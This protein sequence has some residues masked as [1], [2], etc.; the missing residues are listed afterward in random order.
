[1]SEA[2]LVAIASSN[3]DELRILGGL[4]SVPPARRYSSYEAL[5]TDD[6]VD[7]I[8]VA[9]PASHHFEHT[10]LFLTA[11]RGVVCETPFGLN[12]AQAAAMVATAQA[13]GRFLMETSTRNLPVYVRLRELMASGAIGTVMAFSSDYGYAV[14]DPDDPWLD[15]A[16]GGGALL[17]Q[18]IY[19]LSLA[20][21]LLGA[22]E[23]L[24]ALGE[25]GDTGIDEHVAILTSHSGGAT[26]AVTTSLRTHLARTARISGTRGSIT[27]PRLI[28]APTTLVVQSGA[29]YRRLDLPFDREGGSS[30]PGGGF[31][32]EVRHV[33]RRLHD[34]HLNSDVMP[35]GESQSIMRTLD[36]VR[37]Q[38]GARH[39]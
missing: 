3:H 29:Q 12:A 1:M 36:T 5:A 11:G 24:T 20:S 10:V 8:Y 4:H 14:R 31:H 34:G 38:I 9:T 15:P 21:M 2:E 26:A 27:V 6:E 25:I 18:G 33:H 37:A 16:G 13:E 32:H 17:H 39:A 35:L 23:R 22:P 30:V 28:T 19:P 7:L